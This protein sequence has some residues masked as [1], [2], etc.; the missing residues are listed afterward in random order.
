MKVLYFINYAPNYRDV[1]LKELG[2]HVDLTVVS[3]A[4]KEANLKD[5]N[6]RVGYKHICLKRKRFFF[7]INF[8]IKEFTIANG[9]FDVV[10]VGYT[11]WNP[12]RMINLF[13]KRKRVI[14]EGKIFGKNDGFVTRFF[15]RIFVNSGEGLLVYSELVKKHLLK[16]TKRPIIVFNN[17]SY[18]KSD[19]KPLPLN[20]I[21]NSLNVLWVGRYQKRKKLEILIQIAKKYSNIN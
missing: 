18:S 4:G 21:I 3:Y 5:P 12:F 13:R 1:F 14:C 19:L 16:Y 9:D 7:N 17:T 20:P 2:K 10:V 8:N 11:L 6:E 15:R